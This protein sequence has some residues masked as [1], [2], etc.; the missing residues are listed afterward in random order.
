MQCPSPATSQLDVCTMQSY[1]LTWLS[2][3]SGKASL[4][5]ECSSS[6]MPPSEG[7]ASKK[8]DGTSP[9]CWFSSPCKINIQFSYQL[10]WLMGKQE[11]EQ[12]PHAG[13]ARLWSERSLGTHSCWKDPQQIPQLT[14]LLSCSVKQFRVQK[15]RRE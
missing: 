4:S 1:S 5:F 8:L 7:T 2:A 14:F 6:A 15:R 11:I 10:S 13:K 12:Q 9:L 3:L